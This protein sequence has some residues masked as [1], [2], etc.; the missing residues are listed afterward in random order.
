MIFEGGSDGS[1]PRS[2]GVFLAPMPDAEN[3]HLPHRLAVLL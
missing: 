1:I 2:P 3:L